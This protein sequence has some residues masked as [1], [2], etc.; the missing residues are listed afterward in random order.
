[1]SQYKEIL[2]KA[3]YLISIIRS[4]NILPWYLLLAL[5]LIDVLIYCYLSPKGFIRKI[6]QVINLKIRYRQL[7]LK[8]SKFNRGI[9]MLIN[10]FS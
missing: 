2:A 8:T 10:W 4:L 6:R 9:M 3:R 1:M 5:I 7:R